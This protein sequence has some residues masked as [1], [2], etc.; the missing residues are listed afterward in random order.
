M[1]KLVAGL[2]HHIVIMHFV[3]L[4]SRVTLP[5]MAIKEANADGACMMWPLANKLA[6]AGTGLSTAPVA[7][8]LLEKAAKL[9]ALW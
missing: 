2:C 5:P 8:S 9:S 3:C 6:S 4:L 7:H 1:P